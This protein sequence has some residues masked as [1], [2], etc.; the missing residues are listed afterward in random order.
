MLKNPFKNEKRTERSIDANTTRALGGLTMASEQDVKNTDVDWQSIAQLSPPVAPAE[1]AV[2]GLQVWF[3]KQEIATTKAEN[4]HTQRLLGVL[5][6]GSEKFGLV[7]DSTADHGMP[8]RFYLT[9]IEENQQD[10]HPLRYVELNQLNQVRPEGYV[11]QWEDITIGRNADNTV[12]SSQEDVSKNHATLRVSPTDVELI[13]N[14]STNG[15]TIFTAD[16]FN[17]QDFNPALLDAWDYLQANPN[18]WS[19]TQGAQDVLAA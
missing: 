4:G 1:K 6:T 9:S 19:G 10:C 7:A 5:F 17:R 14:N 18:A 8:D 13:D 15:V 16:L 12:V 3:G 11:K 2:R